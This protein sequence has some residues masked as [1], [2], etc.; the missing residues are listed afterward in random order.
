VGVPPWKPGGLCRRAL[1]WGRCHQRRPRAWSGWTTDDRSSIL[2]LVMRGLLWGWPGKLLVA[3]AA[4]ALGC[5][6]TVTSPESAA[7]GSSGT[8]G[9][10]GTGCPSFPPKELCGQAHEIQENCG[11]CGQEG[12]YCDFSWECTTPGDPYLVLTCTCT[13]GSWSCNSGDGTC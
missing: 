3:A 2:G 1:A 8:G 5:G 4:L 6:T 11:P 13:H 12:L 10:G 7:G 9:Q